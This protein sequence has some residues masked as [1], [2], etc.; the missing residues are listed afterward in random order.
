M[1]SSHKTLGMR[2]K[3]ARRE[4]GLS[5]SDLADMTDV[6]QPTVANW[7]NGSHAPRHAALPK[8][9]GALNQTPAD[10]MIA[11]VAAPDAK[12]A[13]FEHHVPIIETPQT[14]GDIDT[15]AVIGYVAVNCAAA[16]PFALIA[17]RD[18]PEQNITR[19]DTLIFDRA[20]TDVTGAPVTLILDN[21]A[22]TLRAHDASAAKKDAPSPARLIMSI[23]HY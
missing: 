9:A 2:I 10:L 3:A 16:R 7:E 6:S 12:P 19:G 11:A 4:L 23:S 15:G 13:L 22:P 5:Q 21:L 8:I 14:A 18:Y 20:Q 1:T 17:D